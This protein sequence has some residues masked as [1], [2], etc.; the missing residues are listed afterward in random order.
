M[1]YRER[2]QPTT[3][4]FLASG[5]IDAVLAFHRATFGETRM[6]GEG[7]GGAGGAGEGSEGGSGTGGAGGGVRTPPA[8]GVPQ[9]QVNAIVARETE[10]AKAQALK[11]FAEKHGLASAEDAEAALK[12]H[13]DAQSAKLS[14]A[15]K[16]EKAAADKEAAATAREAAATAK[17]RDATVRAA[18]AVAGCTGKDDMA[19][20]TRLVQLPDG[21]LD[22]KV[23]EDAVDAL[24]K[25]R[26]ELFGGKR[27]PATPP[28]FTPPGSPAPT[29]SPT[30]MEQARERY[31][32]QQN[33][34]SKSA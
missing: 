27:G 7:A 12:A 11:D 24:K 21:D 30:S 9:D 10:K 13:L 6:D 17:E 29:G 8:A 19:D 20:A 14:D 28:A 2:V 26:P 18:L 22:D 25:R 23:A 3:A 32:N 5:D 1:S 33:G 15:E 4:S 16:R 31:R 34:A